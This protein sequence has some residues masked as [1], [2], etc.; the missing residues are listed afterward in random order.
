MIIIGYAYK[1]EWVKKL[2]KWTHLSN[3]LVF[4]HL[5][6]LLARLLMDLLLADYSEINSSEDLCR[7]LYFYEI[8]QYYLT[9]PI[10]KLFSI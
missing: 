9:Y 8:Q 2:I 6:I 1:W 7:L 5:S 10:F 4:V 3:I